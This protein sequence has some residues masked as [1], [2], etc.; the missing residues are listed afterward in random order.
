MFEYLVG[1]NYSAKNFNFS[2]CVVLTLESK[3][4]ALSIQWRLTVRLALYL[5]PQKIVKKPPSG[6]VYR[7]L[8]Y[9][10]RH[11]RRNFNILYSSCQSDWSGIIVYTQLCVLC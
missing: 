10:I 7:I 2:L 5:E 9:F 6:A 8:H 11:L 4:F 1:S 3:I